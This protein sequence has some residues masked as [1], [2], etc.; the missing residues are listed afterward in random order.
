MERPISRRQTLTLAF[1]AMLSPYLR[2][3]P[4][5]VT[6]LSGRAAWLCPLAAFPAL[7]VLVWLLDRALQ[8]AQ[9]GEG[10]AGQILRVCGKGVGGGMLLAWTG[11]ILFHAG[12]LLRSGADRFI[13]T[14]FPDSEPWLFIAVMVLLTL[15]AAMGTVKALARA[16]EIFYPLMVIVLLVVIA[17]ALPNIHWDYLLPVT[18]RDTVPILKGALVSMNSM[19]LA[20]LYAAFLR[21]HEDTD[22]S[23]SRSF[24]KWLVPVCLLGTAVC[25]VTIGVFGAV[26]TGQLAYPFFI[27]VRDVSVFNTVERIEALV[28]GLWLLP[29]FVL[30]TVE[31]LIASENLMLLFGGEKQEGR[32]VYWTGGGKYVWLCTAAAAVSAVLIAHDTQ[33]LDLWSDTI[34]PAVNLTLA[35][36]VPLLVLAVEKLRKQ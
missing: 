32:A 3:L 21:G 14:I 28:V 31:V 29:D 20:L 15:L 9:P 7:A 1:L 35:F 24:I 34:M 26:T 18:A 22:A 8:G 27:M 16:T 33:E 30:V 36:V 10:M 19:C 11:W 25:V 2:L 12:F 4:G 5:R 13:A 6:E 23:W 17:F